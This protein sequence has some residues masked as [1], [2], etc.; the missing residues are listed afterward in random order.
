MGPIKNDREPIRNESDDNLNIGSLFGE[1]FTKDYIG[2]KKMT[3]KERDAAYLAINA[4]KCDRFY[5]KYDSIA[6]LSSYEKI[7]SRSETSKKEGIKNPKDITENVKTKAP[8]YESTKKSKLDKIEQLPQEEEEGRA[9]PLESSTA[10]VLMRM[11]KQEVEKAKEEARLEKQALKADRIT[12]EII[13]EEVTKSDTN[14][15]DHR[16]FLLHNYS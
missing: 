8:A 11:Q 6:R 12:K 4:E 16:F 2:D 15:V 7:E 1:E 5:Q 3:D 14:Y 13:N 10:F 9:A